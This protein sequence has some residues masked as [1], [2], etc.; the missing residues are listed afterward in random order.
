M[1]TLK[2][3]ELYGPDSSRQ[4]GSAEAYNTYRELSEL[5][6]KHPL[7]N[8]VD[9]FITLDEITISHKKWEIS[10]PIKLA[11]KYDEPLLKC[12]FELYGHSHYKANQGTDNICIQ[13]GCCHF[14]CAPLLDGELYYPES[15]EVLD[16]LIKPDYL[17]QLIQEENLDPKAFK[18]ALA[19][20]DLFLFF[21]QNRVINPK[22]QNLINDIIEQPYQ[23]SM[24]KIYLKSKALELIVCLLRDSNLCINT[25]QYQLAQHDIDILMQI[26]DYIAAEPGASFSL[27]G[28]AR[29]FGINDYKLKKA[30]KILFKKTVFSYILEQRM[31]LSQQLLKHTALDQKDIAMKVGFKHQHHF[32]QRFKGY[33]GFLPSAFRRSL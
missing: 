32:A 15:R 10:Q 19:Q 5:L 33:F 6:I 16:I 1:L 23:G 28:L 7:V 2:L 22:Y 24:A 11:V 29:R 14:F 9:H 3:N 12:Q 8:G 30:F 13:S 20:Q 31:L 4:Q 18:K 27:L 21:N 26:R 17:L 25:A